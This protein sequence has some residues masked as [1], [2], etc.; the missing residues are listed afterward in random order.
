MEKHHRIALSGLALGSALTTVFL[1]APGSAT[2]DERQQLASPAPAQTQPIR[3]SPGEGIARLANR[4]DSA[5]VELPDDARMRPGDLRRR[6]AISQ[7][8]RSTPKRPL[9][10]A[11][12]LKSATS[13]RPVSKTRWN[14]E[15]QTRQNESII[16]K[17]EMRLPGIAPSFSGIELPDDA[18]GATPE[19][20]MEQYV[21][22]I[23]PSLEELFPSD[24]LRHALTAVE[25]SDDSLA[26]FFASTPDFDYYW[27]EIDDYLNGYRESAERN[28]CNDDCDP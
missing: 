3:L 11:L 14:R 9:P 16:G 15:L 26:I 24:S 8:A 5:S 21:Q 17:H 10:T 6:E 12:Q 19:D 23:R 2:A 1:L 27:Q 13:G 7:Q 25:G 28:D 22:N 4:S 18:P 20:R